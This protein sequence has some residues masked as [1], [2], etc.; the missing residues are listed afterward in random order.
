VV[1]AGRTGLSDG[2]QNRGWEHAGHA[3]QRDT[4]EAA[5]QRVRDRR[6]ETK[7]RRVRRDS[8]VVTWRG[9][10]R[11][12]SSDELGSERRL[13]S[14]YVVARWDKRGDGERRRDSAKM[15]VRCSMPWRRRAT[16]MT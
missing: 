11:D 15:V 13:R 16:M 9:T 6:G 4:Q 8:A 3:W 7:G 2:M 14:G 5:Q 1:N 10:G 12:G